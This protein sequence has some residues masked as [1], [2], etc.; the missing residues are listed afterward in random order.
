MQCSLY[1]HPRKT[2]LDKV[3]MTDLGDS[4]DYAIV[5]HPHVTRYVA[6]LMLQTGLLGQF[7]HVEIEPGQAG[8]GRW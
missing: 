4:T 7:R 8:R 1:A 5:S 2:F 3:G 6:E